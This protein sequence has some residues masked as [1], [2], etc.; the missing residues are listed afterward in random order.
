MGEDYE[1]GLYSPKLME[2]IRN[3]RG[4]RFKMKFEKLCVR[5]I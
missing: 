3:M 2:E 5:Q 4:K 1:K